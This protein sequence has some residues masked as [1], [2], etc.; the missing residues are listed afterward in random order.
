MSASALLQGKGN[1]TRRLY[2][3]MRHE[4]HNELAGGAVVDDTVRWITDSLVNRG[5]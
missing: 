1:V 2:P 3:G 4:M 5:R